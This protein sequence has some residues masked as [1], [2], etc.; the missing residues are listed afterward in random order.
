VLVVIDK[1]DKPGLGSRAKERIHALYFEREKEKRAH[2][3]RG[4]ADDESSSDYEESESSDDD[5]DGGIKKSCRFKTSINREFICGHISIL[6]EWFAKKQAQDVGKARVTVRSPFFYCLNRQYTSPMVVA[7][8]NFRVCANV[9]MPH[10]WAKWYSF[11]M[12][13][14]LLSY[15]CS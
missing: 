6:D 10:P 4:D 1:S 13:K 7:G 9:Q 11:V 15:L 5:D 14:G 2:K 3:K 8:H 12:H